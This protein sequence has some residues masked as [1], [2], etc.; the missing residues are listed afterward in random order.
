MELFDNVTLNQ[1]LPA[2]S[3]CSAILSNHLHVVIR[4]RPDV[5]KTWSNHEVALRWLQIFPGKRIDEQLLLEWTGRQ[6]RAG[7]PGK[8][9]DDQTFNVKE[10]DDHGPLLERLGIASGMWCDL[11]WGYKKY[12]GRSRGAGSADHLRE[13]AVA[14]SLSFHPGQKQVRKCFVNA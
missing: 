4:N 10:P 1:L 12:F 3:R 9:R 6:G 11:V 5:V 14:N 2:G 13:D 7:K 8:I